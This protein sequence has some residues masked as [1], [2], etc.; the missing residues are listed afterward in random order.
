MRWRHGLARLLRQHCDVVQVTG[1]A[2]DSGSVGPRRRRTVRAH[3]AH[4]PPRRG[5]PPRPPDWRCGARA[6][7]ARHGSRGNLRQ[8]APP[9]S[10][11]SNLRGIATF[12][13]PCPRHLSNECGAENNTMTEY[14]YK[15]KTSRQA[16]KSPR[17]P[18]SVR[19]AASFPEAAPSEPRSRYW[20][21]SAA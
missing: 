17:S 5:V 6:R 18:E 4:V 19:A 9:G 12:G 15:L 8:A 13:L 14:P 3:L 1:R 7:P 16:S 11:V 2:P 20:W 21:L 10:S